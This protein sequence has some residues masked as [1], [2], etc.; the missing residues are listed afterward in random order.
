MDVV[1]GSLKFN[2]SAHKD[3]IRCVTY[4]PDGMKVATCS[5][6]RTISVWDAE[7]GGRLMEPLEG[8]TEAVLSI[9]FSPS[10]NFLVSGNVRL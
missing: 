9:E 8:H 2:I 5:D 3:W 7:N 1:T 10:G 6:D 4:S